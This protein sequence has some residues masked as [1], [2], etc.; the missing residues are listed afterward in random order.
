[1][2]KNKIKEIYQERFQKHHD[3]LRWLYME[4]YD[5]GSMF[6]ELCD[7][8]ESFFKERNKNL[9]LLDKEREIHS[10]WYKQNDML[11]MMFY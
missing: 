5:N 2:R 6:A 3:E 8:M 7:N 11:G 4:L 9:Q 1:M 10:D